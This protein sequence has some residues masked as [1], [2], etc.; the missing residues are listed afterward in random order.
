MAPGGIKQEE[1][2]C[3]GWW[4]GFFARADFHP[5]SRQDA[6]AILSRDRRFIAQS[7]ERLLNHS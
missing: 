4:R 2:S 3:P 1:L 7:Q 5:F 6:N